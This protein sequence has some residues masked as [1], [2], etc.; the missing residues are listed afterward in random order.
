[1]AN[2]W[3][4]HSEENSST[5]KL[6]GELLAEISYKDNWY[7]KIFD[8]ELVAKWYDEFVNNSDSDYQDKV[9]KYDLHNYFWLAIRILRATAQGSDIDPDNCK[10]GDYHFLCDDCLNNFERQVYQNLEYFGFETLE[11][12][13][14]YI[15]ENGA[16]YMAYDHYDGEDGCSH[17]VCDCVSPDNNLQSY[18]VYNNN[19]GHDDLQSRMLTVINFMIANEPVDWHPG[20]NNQVQDIIHPS[21]YC[22]VKGVTKRKDMNNSIVECKNEA[23]RYSWLPSDFYID[24][25]GNANLLSYINN[26]NVESYPE[27]VPLIEQMLTSHLPA[28]ELVL[29]R[30]YQPVELKDRKLQVIVKIAATHLNESN[31]NYGGGSWHIEGMPYEHI[32][33]TA[34]N[35]LEVDGI[36]DSFLE[37]RKPVYLNEEALTY[38]QN[39]GKH[40]AHHYGANGHYDGVMNAYLGLIKADK[41]SSVV[42]PNTLQHRVK[43]FSLMDGHKQGK[44]IIL[45]FFVVDPFQNIVSTGDV[46]PQ[47]LYMSKQDAEYY[48]ERLMHFRKYHVDELNN[49]V[50]ERSFSLCEH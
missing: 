16:E 29:S 41:W 42:F 13:K 20:S 30:S 10:W 7:S 9:G 38:P 17:V 49:V 31:N 22:Y 3:D 19:H 2:Y 28:L 35:Y 47:Q 6:F 36:T 48:R 8:S 21:L 50:Y 23:T 40:T 27:M 43:P 39:D 45:A 24:E 34:L 25:H 14:E 37:F 5:E 46:D 26:L 4:P 44:R 11:E 15:S 33:A 18:V 12:A 1:M 32:V